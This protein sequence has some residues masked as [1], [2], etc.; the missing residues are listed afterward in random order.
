MI[1]P[2]Y[3]HR[4][5][6]ALCGHSRQH[7]FPAARTIGLCDGLGAIELHTDPLSPRSLSPYANR[8]FALQD[9]I[10]AEK[11]RHMNRSSDRTNRSE[12]ICENE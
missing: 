5:R 10:I 4:P 3:D 8:L 2:R 7:C 1:A 11:T 12:N 9:H 6:F